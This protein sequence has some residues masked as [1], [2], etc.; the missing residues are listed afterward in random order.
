MNAPL[1]LSSASRED[2]IALILAQRE[3]LADQEQELARLRAELATQ[4]TAMAALQERV[5]VLL[6]ALDPP[7]GDNPSS[8]PTTMPGLKPASRTRTPAAEPRPRKRRARGSGRRRMRPTAHQMHAYARCP[9]CAT[10]LQGGTVKRTRE[11]IEVVPGRV[12]VTTHVY[13]ERRCPRCRGRWLPGPEL[14][15]LVVGHGRLGVGLLSLIAV[16]R[17]EL[18]LPVERIQWYLAAVHGLHLSVGGIVATLHTVA[19]RAAPAVEQIRA[20]IRASPVV[21]VDETG[22]RQDGGNGYAWTFSTPTARVFVRGSRER[23]VLEAAVGSAYPGVLVSDFYAAY[24]GYAGRHQ[25]CW[26]HLLRDVDE[27]TEQHRDDAAVR[28]WGDAVHALYQRATAE[29]A[30]GNPAHAR[31]RRLCYEAELGALCAPY[32]GVADAPQRVLC[33]RMTKHL[34]ELFVFVADPAV[35]ATNNAAERSLRHLVTTRKISGGTRSPAGTATKMTLAS[36][37]G[38]WRLQGLNPLVAC[39]ALLADSQL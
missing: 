11:V 10:T 15:G 29:A 27:L 20:S 25:Y 37:F 12:E 8:R 23:A 30:D 26:A 33:E 28:G 32:L 21:H 31:Q 14:D 2:L 16:L 24:T 39:R 17:E 7:D 36:L 22:W 19:A 13:V 4:Q 18:R 5:G 34:A 3:R 1:D 35:P 9:H 6:A 38:T